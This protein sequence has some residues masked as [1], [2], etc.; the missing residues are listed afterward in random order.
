[1]AHEGLQ[2]PCIDTAAC[3]GVAGRVAQHVGVDREGEASGL[4]EAF[5]E[6]LRAIDG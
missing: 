6:L 4:A 2:D 3:Q 1:M 5:Y